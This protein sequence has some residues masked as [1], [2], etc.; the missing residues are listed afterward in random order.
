MEGSIVGRERVV[1][2]LVGHIA[3]LLH[4]YIATLLQC[5]VRLFERPLLRLRIPVEEQW[6]SYLAIGMS[7]SDPQL[8]DAACIEVSVTWL[9]IMELLGQTRGE[10]NKR[11]AQTRRD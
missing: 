6:R 8:T 7:P 3:T 11:P 10:T 9:Q 1:D 5:I 2:T 4:C